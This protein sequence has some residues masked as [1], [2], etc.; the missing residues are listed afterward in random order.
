MNAQIPIAMIAAGHTVSGLAQ[1]YNNN[2]Y[3]VSV[4]SHAS[5]CKHQPAMPIAGF[6]ICDYDHIYPLTT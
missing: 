2:G 1:A 3:R 5:K 6:Q 4:S